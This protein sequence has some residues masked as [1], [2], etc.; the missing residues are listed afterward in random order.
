[1][2]NENIKIIISTLI[3]LIFSIGA[4]SAAEIWTADILGN[5]KYDFSPEEI[6]YIHGQNF[7]QNSIIN[8]KVIRPNSVEN[9]FFAISDNIGT[10]L[11]SYRL[12]GIKGIYTIY[13]A[14]GVN[15][16][17]FIF[18]DSAIW[19]TNNDCGTS[20]QDANHFSVNDNVYINGDGFDS[21]SYN[22]TITVKLGGASCD[23][24]IIVAS[25]TQFVNFSGAFCF[26]AYNVQ[27]DDCGE[28]QVKFEQKGDN[29]RVEGNACINDSQCGASTMVFSCVDATLK[30]EKIIPKC[31]NGTC[32]LTNITEVK[33][34]GNIK[35]EL[36]CSENKIINTTTIPSCSNERC[37]NLTIKDIIQTCQFGCSNAHCLN[38]TQFCGDGIQQIN[39]QCDD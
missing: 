12:D 17:Q 37:S 23:P 35:S 2:I 24:E 38:Q 33:S 21:R 4:V 34:C 14:D 11:T 16:A 7:S 8:V 27:S 26:N 29:Y 20:Q 39:E 6:V 5:P 19:T 3:F 32:V 15:N 13:V 18:T 1:M 30:K 10:F 28:Y 25:G 22:W 36:V 31:I 9:A